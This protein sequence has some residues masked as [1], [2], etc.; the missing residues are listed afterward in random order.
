VGGWTALRPA[1][2]IPH[3]KHALAA[4]LLALDRPLFRS[5]PRCCIISTRLGLRFRFPSRVNGPNN[6]SRLW[7][8]CL[9]EGA[10]LPE[11]RSADQ[12][13]GEPAAGTRLLRLGLSN[14]LR[15]HLSC[16]RYLV[17]LNAGAIAAAL[18]IYALGKL[19]ESVGALP[20]FIRWH[21]FDVLAAP[22]LLGVA[23]LLTLSSPFRSA[24]FHRVLPAAGVTAIGAFIWEGVA[25]AFSTSTRDPVDV[26]AYAVGMVLFLAAS[27]A[28][29]AKGGLTVV[30]A[31]ERLQG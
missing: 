14:S 7:S 17:G 5:S 31:D 23:N 24:P 18:G 3:G 13:S 28:F 15:N 19:A 21:L 26:V 6:V 25:P 10:N 29:G 11:L 16:N 8:R 27:W 2:R 20:P 30:A 12:L 4:E 1:S 22:A 9:S